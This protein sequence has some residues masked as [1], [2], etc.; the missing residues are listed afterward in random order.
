MKAERYSVVVIGGGQAGLSVSYYLKQCG[1]SHVVLEKARIAQSW[2]SERW[3]AF[4]LVTP[5]WQCQLPDFPYAGADPD[6]FMPKHEIVEYVQAFAN[7][8][9]PPVREGVEVYAVRRNRLL[10]CYELATSEGEYTADAVV[11]ATG[12]FHRP[13]IPAGAKTIPPRITQLHSA[14]YK[15][16]GALPEGE[17]LVAGSGQSGCQIA[18]DLHL[19]GRKV[20][21]CLGDAPRSPRL[22]RGKDVVAWLDQFGYYD[23]PIDTHPDV[24]MVR[25]KTNHYLTGRGGGRE[26]DLRRFALDGMKLYGFLTDVSG[27]AVRF[28]P[29]LK[30]RLDDADDV[31]RGI[32]RLIDTYIEEHGVEA[33]PAPPPYQPVWEPTSEPTKLDLVESGI[34][35]VIWS[36]GFHHDFSFVKAPVFDDR[37]YPRHSRGITHEPGLYFI[38]LSWLYT[39]GSARFSGVARDAEH[40]VRH[41]ADNQDSR[42]EVSNG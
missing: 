37:G 38:G 3:D 29:D 12:T 17:V 13:R 28:A 26:I 21:L 8:F 5:N 34:T 2:R 10:G 32:C 41:I 40:I 27:A 19:A 22:Y 42:R 14:Q 20:H 18:E 35:S 39:W 1:I 31:Y 30:R 33:P 9:D 11:V 23:T 6:G 25:K 24:E 15:N 4:C 7:H 16:P 36:I